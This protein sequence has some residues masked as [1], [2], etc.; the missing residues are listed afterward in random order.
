MREFYP[1]NCCSNTA[2]LGELY[3]RYCCAFTTNSNIR[4][5]K[6]LTNQRNGITI[7]ETRLFI[8]ILKE[9]IVFRAAFVGRSRELQVLDNLW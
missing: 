6:A 8:P 4:S 1:S 2:E 7:F 3:S 9:G 5:K